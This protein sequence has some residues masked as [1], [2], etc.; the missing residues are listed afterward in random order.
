M[1]VPVRGEVHV[2]QGREQAKEEELSPS[3]S[4]QRNRCFDIG[5]KRMLINVI[6]NAINSTL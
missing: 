4:I 2:Y 3:T 1:R 6:E 5:F